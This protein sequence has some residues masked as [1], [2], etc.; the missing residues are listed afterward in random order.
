MEIE[1]IGDCVLLYLEPEIGIHRWKYNTKENH[2][3][4]VKLHAQ[5]TATPFNI[6]RKDFYRQELP[7][8]VIENG[9][10]RDTILHLKAEVEPAA[11]PTLIA[12]KLN[13]L[14][15]LKLNTELI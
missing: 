13:E 8:R 7:R 1:L 3:Y 5:K 11:L 9:T 10:I 6:H 2:R 12:S 4:L 14:F 15:E